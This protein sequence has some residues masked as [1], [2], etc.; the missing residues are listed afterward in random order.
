MA[1]SLCY[2][3]DSEVLSIQSIEKHHF[4]IGKGLDNMQGKKHDKATIEKVLTSYYITGNYGDTAKETGIA[5]STCRDLVRNNKDKQEFIEL[6]NKKNEYFI[7]KS[8]QIINS[9]LDKLEKD[10]DKANVGTLSTTLGI[11]Y[12][13]RALASGEATQNTAFNVNIKVV[14]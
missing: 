1:R 8:T 6:R 10:I 11:L 12:D 14:K 7:Q 9:I 13:K 5:E 4:F 3:L 2:T